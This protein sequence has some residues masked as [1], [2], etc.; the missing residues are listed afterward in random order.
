MK[1]K[2]SLVYEVAAMKISFWKDKLEKYLLNTKTFLVFISR[3]IE[4]NFIEYQIRCC[5]F[6]YLNCR[7]YMP[8]KVF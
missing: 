2:K 1:K 3:C 5:L 8:D 7:G 4:I 6:N